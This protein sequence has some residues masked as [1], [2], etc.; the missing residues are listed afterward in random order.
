MKNDKTTK[1]IQ[2]LWD[3][4]ELG[5]HLFPH[6]VDIGLTL[7]SRW[8]VNNIA[9]YCTVKPHRQIIKDLMTG[10]RVMSLDT[11]LAPKSAI[12]IADNGRGYSI[13]RVINEEHAEMAC[14]PL[15]YSEYRLAFK[16]AMNA[17]QEI[18]QAN[19]LVLAHTM[20]ERLAGGKKPKTAYAIL[21]ANQDGIY[22]RNTRSR[23][24]NSASH[25]TQK[26]SSRIKKAS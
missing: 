10:K 1:A 17:L 5:I 26:Q 12:Y 9:N 7:F 4:A 20:H 11:T 23:K 24:S 2:R 15:A 8:G 13:I 19:A 16:F 21:T 3:F 25:Q 22:E 6:N 18:A 14:M